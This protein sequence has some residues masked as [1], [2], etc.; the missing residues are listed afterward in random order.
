MR[1]LM[2]FARGRLWGI[3][4]RM[5]DQ[6][7][8]KKLLVFGNEQFNYRVQIGRSIFEH[9][10]MEVLRL[11]LVI[12][13]TYYFSTF[14]GY[15]IHKWIHQSRSGFL[16]IAHL[17]HHR[18]QYPPGN[19]TSDTYRSAGRDN[20]TFLFLPFILIII[21]ILWTGYYFNIVSLFYALL[22]SVEIVIISLIHDVL[23]NSFHLNRSLWHRYPGFSRLKS[24]HFLHHWN[25][26]KNYGIIDFTWDKILNT[27]VKT[28]VR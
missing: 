9:L 10:I 3:I 6:W 21:G 19:L 23:H 17:N 11:L 16:N 18:K 12:V 7:R 28:D 25:M 27:D 2:F 13:L 1:Q 4:P 15:Q 24:K 8:S 20:T 14:I 26:R 5:L 22:I